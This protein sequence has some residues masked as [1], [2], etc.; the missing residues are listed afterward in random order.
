MNETATNMLALLQFAGGGGAAGGQLATMLVTFGLI[1]MIFYFLVIR[2]QNR[3]QKETKAMLAQLKK[4]DRVQ[5]SGGIRG[6]VTAVKEDAVTVKVDDATKIEF[7]KPS[8][9]SI[10]DQRQGESRPA[11]QDKEQ[12]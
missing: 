10:L 9:T 6:V 3:R 5:T 8:I 7:A 11:S 1:I 4:G 2:P 12:S